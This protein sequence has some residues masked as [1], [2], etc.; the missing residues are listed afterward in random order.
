M[1]LL[2]NKTAQIS[3]VMICLDLTDEIIQ[4]AVKN[5]INF[6]ISHHPIFTNSKERKASDYQLKLLKT[7]KEKKIAFA[8]YHTNLD[9]APDGMNHYVAKQLDLS[10]IK[11]I[12]GSGIITGRIGSA[13]RPKVFASYIK[14]TFD[15][16]R[17]LYTSDELVKTVAICSGAGFSMFVEHAHALKGI[18][19][20]VTGD[21]K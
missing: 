19:L 2:P 15:L 3:G 7:L 12:P 21:M 20:L 11:N 6:I 16:E 10:Q 1:A 9:N 13:Y 17:V 8:S 14:N 4:Q 5:E 18:D